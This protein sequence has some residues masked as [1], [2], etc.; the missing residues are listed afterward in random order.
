L[1]VF[2]NNAVGAISYKNLYLSV[3][4]S[5]FIEDERVPRGSL[6][7]GQTW[8]YVNKRGGPDKRFT[9]NHEIPIVEYGYIDLT[10]DTGLNERIC[11]SR[12]DK[13]PY[14]EKAIE[15]LSKIVKA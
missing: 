9:N 3:Y 11:L 7:V 15:A 5:N 10:S 2:E 4:A 12:T 1:L 13:G 8:Q 14:F 6:I